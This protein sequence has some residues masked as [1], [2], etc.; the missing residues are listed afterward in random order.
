MSAYVFYGIIVLLCGGLLWAF[1]KMAEATGEARAL[2]AQAEKDAENAKAAGVE[3]ARH[4]T[5]ADTVG[6][7]QD[8]G[9]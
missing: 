7:M 6:R 1:A 5:T 3:V 9:F 2:R 4:T 8:G